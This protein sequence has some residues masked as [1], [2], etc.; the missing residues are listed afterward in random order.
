MNELNE[1]CKYANGQTT[2]VLTVACV[3]GIGVFKSTANAGTDL[4]G[5]VINVYWSSSERDALRGWAQFFY[6]GDQDSAD[7]YLRHHVRPVRA[8]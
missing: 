3:Q 6:T 1:L 2:G 8:F 7:K 5:F 4:G